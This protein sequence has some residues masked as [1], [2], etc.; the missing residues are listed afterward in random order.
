[1]TLIKNNL[2]HVRIFW[3]KYLQNIWR[4]IQWPLIA[5]LGFIALA[6]GFI[7]FEKHYEVLGITHSSLD[8]FY[9]SIKLFMFSA[10]IDIGPMPIEL[11]LSRFL[12]PIVFFYTAISALMVILD[13]QIQF[14]RLKLIRGH[15]IVCGL[16]QKGIHLVKKLNQFGYQVV[17]IE[18]D[19]SNDLIKT[20]KEQG[21]SLL[22]GDAKDKE[23]L[24]KV[25]VHK[26][27][28][29]VSFCGDDST[30]I[31]VAI[32]SRE[33]TMDCKD[34]VLTCVA[35]IV[36][37]QVCQILGSLEI[38]M[39]KSDCFK[40]E[41]FN[42]FDIGVQS[43]LKQYP[44]HTDVQT[45]PHILIVGLGNVGENLLVQVARNW[46]STYIEKGVRLRITIID[47]D[48]EVK[49]QLL[50]L[51]Y[52]QLEKVCE[53]SEVEVDIESEFHKSQFL[54][55]SEKCCDITSVYVCLDEDY[56]GLSV[57]LLLCKQLKERKVPIV[58][59]TNQDSGLATLL[60]GEGYD[61][62]H[63]FGLLDWACSPELV[64]GGV[65]EVLA[66]AIHEDYLTQQKSENQTIDPSTEPWEDLS[67]DIKES[68]RDQADHIGVR[69]KSIGCG[70]A[71][72]T[73]WDAD[74]FE[75][76]TEEV[77]LMAE[78]EH[79]RWIKERSSKGW[80]FGHTKNVEKKISPY[81]IPYRELTE[82]VKEYDRNPIRKI[83]VY[84]AQTGFQIYRL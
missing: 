73:E 82:E 8:L 17:V 41:F 21:V 50:C 60:S 31:Q 71:P 14:I 47:K 24:R 5:A 58:L 46:Q 44:A 11:E 55:N 72:L 74:S 53:L 32:N 40:I 34:R 69:L 67:E 56:L 43:L 20:C 81:L 83:P 1:M 13:E 7:G 16:G 65:R 9:V 54:L 80:K 23:L 18:C 63:V 66:R 75:F 30:N 33:L 27:K 19:E 62:L 49:K 6:L 64:L 37:P 29:I 26:A 22:L 28:Y 3:R 51:R 2:Q 35:N 79:E 78:M 4:N 57:A 45:T 76:T 61:N 84:L 38:E 77:E 36:N 59:Q 70:I 10:P 48:V 39:E 68:N 52:P 42:I 15:I 25:G 12:A